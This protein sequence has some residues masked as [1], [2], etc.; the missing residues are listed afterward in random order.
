MP[1]PQMRGGIR[2]DLALQH[3]LFIAFTP[4][5]PLK[6]FE[7]P[8]LPVFGHPGKQ[9][10]NCCLFIRP[11]AVAKRA[12]VGKGS[13]NLR[14]ASIR[15]HKRSKPLTRI[16]KENLMHKDERCRR[17]FD[18]RDDGAIAAHAALSNFGKR[19]AISSPVKWPTHPSGVV[20]M[21]MAQKS[22]A[23]PVSNQCVIPAGT[24]MRSFR[25]QI[26][27]CTLPSERR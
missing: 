22:G 9:K 16:G 1:F 15:V 19:D 11:F 27:R 8:S 21:R 4:D 6:K 7:W 14:H 12:R 18:I 17:P 20:K 23:G 5:K 24:L 2:I 13:R 26:T 25:S 3:A 10:R